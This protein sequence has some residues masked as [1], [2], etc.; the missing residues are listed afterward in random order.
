MLRCGSASCLVVLET[1]FVVESCVCPVVVHC[2]AD[3]GTLVL[4]TRECTLVVHL[5][6]TT[7][8]LQALTQLTASAVCH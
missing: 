3:T 7:S 1:M 5:V 6:A 8:H 4:N 2:V